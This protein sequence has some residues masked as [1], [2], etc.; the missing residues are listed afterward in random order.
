MGQ[1]CY[2]QADLEAVR[3]TESLF[4]SPTAL[5]TAMKTDCILHGLQTYNVLILQYGLHV[6]VVRPEALVFIAITKLG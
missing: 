1:S 4:P 5:E 6:R 2:L 3:L